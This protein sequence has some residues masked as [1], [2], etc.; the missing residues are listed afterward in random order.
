M[1]NR[2]LYPAGSYILHVGRRSR[3]ID[4]AVEHHNNSGGPNLV[5]GQST[6]ITVNILILI[7]LVR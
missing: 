1:A 5:G 6:I 7:N 4:A 3:M 2:N